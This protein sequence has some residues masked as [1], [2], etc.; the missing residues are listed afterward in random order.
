M[1]CDMGRDMHCDMGRDMHCD[2][3]NPGRKLGVGL[4]CV[5]STTTGTTCS[6]TG[7]GTKSGMAVACRNDMSCVEFFSINRAYFTS[8]LGSQIRQRASGASEASKLHIS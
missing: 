2:M 6:C 4:S 1:H 8:V 5:F 7:L 3:G